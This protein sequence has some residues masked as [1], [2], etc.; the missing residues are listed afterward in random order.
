MDPRKRQEEEAWWA[1]YYDGAKDKRADF[2]P[3]P[4]PSTPPLYRQGYD[5]GYRSTRGPIRRPGREWDD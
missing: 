1:G 5:A 3:M 2:D 4:K